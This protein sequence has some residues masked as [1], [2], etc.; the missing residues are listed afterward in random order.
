MIGND[1]ILE[2]EFGE[3]PQKAVPRDFATMLDRELSMGKLK[4]TGKTYTTDSRKVNDYAYKFEPQE[5]IE[6]EYNGKKY[7]S[8]PDILS[9]ISRLQHGFRAPAELQFLFR[10]QGDWDLLIRHILL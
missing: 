10:R 6:Y 4:E 5:H 8:M 9:R 1:G 7:G 2:V 3:Y